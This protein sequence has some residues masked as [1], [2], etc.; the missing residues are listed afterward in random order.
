MISVAREAT[1]FALTPMR[2]SLQQLGKEVT[3]LL[4]AKTSTQLQIEH[5]TGQLGLAK[6]TMGNAIEARLAQLEKTQESLMGVVENLI[7]EKGSDQ[8]EE[9]NKEV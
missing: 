1:E 2:V 7:A 5:L 9:D 3:D 8:E 6:D 4:G